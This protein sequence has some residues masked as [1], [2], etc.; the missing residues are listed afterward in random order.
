MSQIN[1]VHTTSSYLSKGAFTPA[2]HCWQQK[3]EKALV[4]VDNIHVDNKN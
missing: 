1:S 2:Q 4:N 3:R